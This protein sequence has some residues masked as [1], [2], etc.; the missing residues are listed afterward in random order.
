MSKLS[1]FD[2]LVNDFSNTFV[3][4]S[5]ADTFHPSFVTYSFRA[6]SGTEEHSET[7]EALLMDMFLNALFTAAA[8]TGHKHI[9]WRMWPVSTFADGWHEIKCRVSLE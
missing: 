4:R 1:R 9:I 5:T 2:L 6:R 3:R 7:I 8:T